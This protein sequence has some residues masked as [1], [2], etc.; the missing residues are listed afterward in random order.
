MSFPKTVFMFSGQGS[1][2]RTMGRPLFETD[3]VFRDELQRLDR[4]ASDLTGE[5]VLEQM[6]AGSKADSFAR[7][8]ITHPAIFMLEYALAQ[9]LL[10]K[11]L[12]PDL[13]LGASLG[14]FAAA[15]VAG[16][17]GVEDAMRAV[18]IQARAF[19]ATCEEGGILAIL[20]P[21][22]LYDEPFLHAHSELS[23][24]NFDRHF[25][26]SCDLSA[27]TGIERELK[28][29]TIASQRLDVSHAF[30]S[31]LIDPAAHEFLA[32]IRDLDLAADAR[33]VACCAR[34]RTL[35]SLEPVDFWDAV[36]E[37]IRFRDTIAHLENA[38]PYRYIDVGPSGTLATFVKYALPASSRSTA[39]QILSPFGQD[40]KNL[41]NLLALVASPEA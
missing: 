28:Q 34:A 23:G 15:A 13:S 26:V 30:H 29:R 14:S 5:R 8:L 18:V 36:R 39:H 33:P 17:L 21:P 31:R 27:M 20:A 10:A 2:Y 16:H 19:E 4:M 1:Q 22:S 9:A 38:G 32:G 24:I 6:H 25:A 40:V 35:S 41:A 7:T 11:G 12:E 37:P 3:P